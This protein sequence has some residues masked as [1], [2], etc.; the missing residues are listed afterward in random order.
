MDIGNTVISYVP[1]SYVCLDIKKALK[2]AK[3]ICRV[4]C[5]QIDV[6]VSVALLCKPPQLDVGCTPVWS[7][8]LRVRR[9]AMWSSPEN[10]EQFYVGYQAPEVGSGVLGRSIPPS[11]D[12]PMSSWYCSYSPSLLRSTNIQYPPKSHNLKPTLKRYKGRVPSIVAMITKRNTDNTPTKDNNRYR[13]V[14][15]SETFRTDSPPCSPYLKVSKSKQN[16]NDKQ[17]WCQRT[18]TPVSQEIKR[19]LVKE[20][21][22]YQGQWKYSSPKLQERKIYQPYNSRDSRSIPTRPSSLTIPP[23]PQGPLPP[24]PG[25]PMYQTI[26]SCKEYEAEILVECPQSSTTRDHRNVGDQRQYYP[27]RHGRPSM[28]EM[29]IFP[30]SSQCSITIGGPTEESRPT[31]TLLTPFSDKKRREST[32][33]FLQ[34]DLDKSDINRQKLSV[35]IVLSL[36]VIAVF[37]FYL[38][39]FLAF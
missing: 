32:A 34:D 21:Q 31:D 39:Y 15:F 4:K 14:K 10:E 6:N 18:L 25:I 33:L 2:K 17:N 38:V 35:V 24:V 22:R 3:N 5:R 13:P 27:A 28:T 30:S 20:D 26:S 7:V 12:R 16:E 37:I 23:P 1:S 11:R 29:K 8:D 36:F 9:R 19:F